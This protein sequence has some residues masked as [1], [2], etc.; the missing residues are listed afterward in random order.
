MSQTVTPVENFKT[1]LDLPNAV[2]KDGTEIIE[3][4]Q[5]GESRQMPLADAVKFSNYDLATGASSGVCDLAVSQTF[6]IDLTVA[7]TKA[8]SFSNA[9]AAR[10]KPIVLKF[11]GN[12]GSVTWPAGVVWNQN[13]APE[14]GATLTLVVFY[15][16]GANFIGAQ[17]ATK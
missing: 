3:V 16:D 2:A 12:I 8:I 17:G 14:M 10:S 11:L 15:W 9:P 13:T 1:V 6:T 5:D 7:G 4:I